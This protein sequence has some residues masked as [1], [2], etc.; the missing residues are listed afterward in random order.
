MEMRARRCANTNCIFLRR[1]THFCFRAEKIPRHRD[2]SI[3]LV[4]R[5]D[6]PTPPTTARKYFCKTVDIQKSRD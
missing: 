2:R 5:G 3:A 4:A 1:K 6:A